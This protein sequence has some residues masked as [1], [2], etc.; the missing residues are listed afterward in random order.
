MTASL[1]AASGLVPDNSA[2]RTVRAL[3]H[4]TAGADPGM[5]PRILEPVAKLGHVS[6]R[7]HA[8][9]EAGDG[10]QLT[11]DLRLVDVTPR[12][13]ELIGLALRAVVGIGQVI[14]VVEP[15]PLA[16]TPG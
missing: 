14:A 10:R 16:D 15:L 8:S 6:A 13:A 9:R 7:V 2:P 11:V 1:R 12:T 3:F 4:I 5:L